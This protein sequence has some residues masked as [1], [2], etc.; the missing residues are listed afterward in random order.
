MKGMVNNMEN[1]K[2]TLIGLIEKY[3][4]FRALKE[5]LSEATKEINEEFKKIQ[6]EIV[7][8]MVEDDV[9]SQGY[10][11]YNYS[12]QTVTHYSFK[13]EETLSES[14]IDKMA[15]M[16]ENGYDYLIKETINQRSLESAMKEAAESE[17]GIPADIAEIISSY[18]ELKVVRRKTRK[19]TMNSAKRAVAKAK[20]TV[21]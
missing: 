18:D 21:K 6:E 5:E 17:N 16:R 19:G 4:E 11:D 1:V 10:G 9:P 15:V 20:G 2:S 13:S 8:Q 3:E 12:P 14:K 7:E